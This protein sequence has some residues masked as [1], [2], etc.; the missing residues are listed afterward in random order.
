MQLTR[1]LILLALVALGSAACSK[2]EHGEGEGPAVDSFNVPTA[3]V[4]AS[5]EAGFTEVTGT[6]EGR[7][8]VSVSTKLMS[9]IH[10]FFFCKIWI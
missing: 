3:T 5:T 9:E 4:Q 1:F 10:L 6:I 8:V 2:A 7:V